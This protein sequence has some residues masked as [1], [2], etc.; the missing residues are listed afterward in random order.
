MQPALI[1]GCH[2]T[3]NI[4]RATVDFGA[5]LGLSRR[6]DR[7]AMGACMLDSEAFAFMERCES[8]NSP[9]PLLDDLLQM[10]SDFGFSHLI[11][12][13]VPMGGQ[14]LAAMV[15][16]NG[17]PEGWF[18]RYSEQDYA[19]ID[20]VCRHSAATT[21]P[22]YWHDVPPELSETEGSRRV[23]K[24]AREFGI[25]SG[26]AVPFL[27]LQHWQSVVSFASGYD[28]CL[29]SDRERSQLVSMATFA[30]A[31]VEAMVSPSDLTVRLT[32]RE[33]EVLLWVAGGKTCY[34]IGEILGIAEVTVKKHTHNAREK[35]G[36]A[37]TIQAVVQA[38]RMRAIS[39]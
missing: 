3:K 9:Q 12:S 38:T 39:P 6:Q 36:V 34:E 4:L 2:F 32:E 27:S 31:A 21:R 37:T 10:A 14:Q 33:K 28:D 30:G 19:A 1:V 16:L 13:G 20:G 35:L 29:M 26:F 7:L 17:W 18:E 11:L 22:F 24:E 5:L 8:Y 23:S 15:E 25:R